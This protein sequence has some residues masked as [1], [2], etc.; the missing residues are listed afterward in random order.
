[1]LKT[2]LGVL[3]ISAGLWAQTSQINGVVRDPSGSVM[4]GAAIKTT[5][6]ATGVVRTATSGTD[7][8]YAIPNLPTGPYMVEVTKEGF[9]KFV[10]TGIVLEVASS[11]TLDVAMRVGA[12]SEQVTVE[13]T[14][15]SVETRSNSIGQVVDN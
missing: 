2:V 14:T 1:M 3:F 13:A 15:L 8:S 9:S 6:T 7:G 4:P 5:Q 12:V 11:A 10:Q